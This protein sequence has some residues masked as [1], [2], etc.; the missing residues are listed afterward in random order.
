MPHLLRA[1]AAV[2]V[3]LSV[4]AG[5]VA[6][7]DVAPQRGWQQVHSPH[8]RVMGDVNP[9][10]LREVAA[11]LERLHALLDVLTAN[12]ATATPDTTVLV[13]RTRAS[14]RPFQPTHDGKVVDVGGY[15]QPGP[16]NY[17]TLLMTQESETQSVVFHEYIHLVLNRALG[18]V[19]P[20]VGE[21]LAE[22]Y[23]TFDVIDGGKTARLGRMLQ[24]HLW[25]LQEAML[26]LDQL[27]RVTHDSPEYNERNKKT[28]FYAQSWALI[29]YLQLGQQRKYAPRFAAFLDAVTRGT[30]FASACQTHLGVSPATLEEELKRYVFANVLYQVNIALPT[31][32]EAIERLAATP[33]PEAETHAVLGDLVT[34]LDTRPDGREHLQHAL[35]VDATQPLALAALAQLEAQGNHLEAARDL[36]MRPRGSPTFQSEY[37]RALALDRT[38]AEDAVIHEALRASIALNPSFALAYVALAQQ[39]GEQEI[40]R[41]EAK[42]LFTKAIVLAPARED[43]RLNLAR[44][45]LL[46]RDVAAARAILGPLAGGGS[47]VAIK[48]AAREWLARSAQLEMAATAVGAAPPAR[49][50]DAVGPVDP[51]DALTSS[52]PDDAL[53]AV[54]VLRR[55]AQ[56]ETRVFGSLAAIE[57][58]AGG[59]V[60]VA[61]VPGGELRV[62]AAAL[63]QVTFTSFRPDL[64]MSMGC[65]PL[66]PVAALITYRP[67]AAG[68]TAGVAVAV[69][70]TPVGYRP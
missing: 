33:V 45:H 58:A 43:F 40:T 59:V 11:R 47:T 30:A 66:A 65:G 5:A 4:G 48:Q 23:S 14:Y 13:F 7:A 21:G 18:E 31:R 8:F 53:Y 64:A 70:F 36:A 46:N 16:M 32:L 26:P 60:L 6:W 22:F 19:A 39:L 67:G 10:A 15:F 35:R 41:E 55:V 12:A 69:E 38:K 28:V 57:C 63:D 20:W 27:V 42:G 29:H 62:R 25:V 24:A 54:P 56:G 17:I 37:Y 9:R 2:A 3:F 34:L 49:A 52:G 44:L 51:A 68:G 1:V 50:A 61:A